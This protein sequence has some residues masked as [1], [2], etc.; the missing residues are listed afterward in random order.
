MPRYFFHSQTD[1]RMTDMEGYELAT[2]QEARQQAIQTCGQMMMDGAEV[3]W[4]SRPWTVTV[5]DETGLILWEIT[6]D[7]F[8]APAS[9]ELR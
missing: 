5:T 2:P 1:T 4:G 7:G 8:A 9:L 3:F 6:M